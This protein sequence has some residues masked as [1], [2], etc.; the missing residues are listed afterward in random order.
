MR[1]FKTLQGLCKSCYSQVTVENILSG[2]TAFKLGNSYKYDTFRL[3]DEALSEFAKLFSTYIYSTKEKQQQ[4]YE[5]IMHG[6]GDYSY[7][8]CFYLYKSTGKLYI[9]NSLS[10]EAFTYCRREFMKTI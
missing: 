7:F 1:T 6:R 3:A 9:S 8:Q 10:G 2:R 4:V 5:A